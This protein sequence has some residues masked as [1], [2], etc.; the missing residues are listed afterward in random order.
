LGCDE[1]GRRFHTEGTESTE[2][3]KPK[4]L[5]GE[6]RVHGVFPRK[7]ISHRGHR[8]HRV[9]ETEKSPRGTPGARVFPRKKISHREHRDQNGRS[10]RGHGGVQ[11]ENDFRQRMQSSEEGRRFPPGTQGALGGAGKRV[12]PLRRQGPI[13][14]KMDSCLRRNDVKLSGSILYPEHPVFPVEICLLSNSARE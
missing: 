3:E 12:S 6:H 5:H 4:N 11:E 1:E 7:K 14:R 2:S 8:E 13:R 9:R 10:P